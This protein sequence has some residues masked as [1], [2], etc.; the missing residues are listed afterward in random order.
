MFGVISGVDKIL[1]SIDDLMAG[2][3]S[4]SDV[5]RHFCTAS[6]DDLQL[7]IRVLLSGHAQAFDQGSISCQRLLETTFRP[8]IKISRQLSRAAIPRNMN[9]KGVADSLWSGMGAALADILA[10]E[11]IEDSKGV[12]LQSLLSLRKRAEFVRALVKSQFPE[13][14]KEM[15]PDYLNLELIVAIYCWS[16][17]VLGDVLGPTQSCSILSMRGKQLSA[18]LARKDRVSC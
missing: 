4:N 11:V 2:R 6:D 14:S 12:V 15:D 1:G 8:F 3:N 5:C 9:T 13:V 10:V 17:L 18:W 7:Q 16:W